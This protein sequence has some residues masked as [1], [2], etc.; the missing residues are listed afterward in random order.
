MPSPRR[1]AA[2]LVVL[3]ACT[4]TAACAEGVEST[5][6]KGYIDGK[7]VITRLAEAERRAPGKVEGET[8][9]GKQV[10]L[11]DFEGKVVVVNVWWSNCPPCRAEAKDLV[12][13]SIELAAMDVEFL[14]INTRDSSP[15]AGRAYE[16][17]YKVPY[18]SIFDADGQN[19]LAFSRTLSPNSIPS[20]L[21][22]DKQGRVAAS[23]L[24]E[25]TS[26]TTLINLV[27]DVSK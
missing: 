1:L 25:V 4:T 22:I 17:R 12:E 15:S 8:L 9:D 3:L 7:G 20:T 19:L 14:G 11:A 10:S 24:G 16:R 26:K 2:A 13:A 21:I 5:G 23:I 18:S 27:E 6:D